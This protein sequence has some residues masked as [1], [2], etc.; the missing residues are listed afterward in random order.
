MLIELRE[1]TVRPG[2]REAWVKFMEEAIIPHHVANGVA[3]LGSWIVED[4]ENTFVW[5]RGFEDEAD[6]V[7]KSASMNES[8][9]W[10]NDL[11]PRIEELVDREK[12]RVKRLLA[13][14]ASPIR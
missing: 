11:L 2:K 5:M 12:H 1:Y 10:K 14:P 8:D 6:R 13:T 9:H 7:K 4:E 3:I